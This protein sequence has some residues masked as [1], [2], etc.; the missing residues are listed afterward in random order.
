MT[1]PPPARSDALC[2]LFLTI[3]TPVLYGNPSSLFFPVPV[4]AEMSSRHPSCLATPAAVSPACRVLLSDLRFLHAAPT[5]PAGSS[6]HTAQQRLGRRETKAAGWLRVIARE[7]NVVRKGLASLWGYTLRDGSESRDTG[8]RSTIGALAWSR[9]GFVLAL[10]TQRRTH[11]HM[12]THHMHT[13]A[14]PI[15]IPH[16]PHRCTR[17]QHTHRKKARG[18]PGH[19]GRT[20]VIPLILSHLRPSYSYLRNTF[21]YDSV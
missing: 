8:A 10:Y 21:L 14:P 9:R 20:S 1:V 11:I 3:I 5:A 4:P 19:A 17:Q 16:T 13:A 2:V 7:G 12:H 6:S 18:A 15:R